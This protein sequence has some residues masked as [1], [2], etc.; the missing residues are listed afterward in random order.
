MLSFLE[1][2]DLASRL[3]AVTNSNN[4]Q[5][6]WLLVRNYTTLALGMRSSARAILIVVLHGHSGPFQAHVLQNEKNGR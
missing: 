6:Y 4:E 3:V 5:R 2:P 1:V